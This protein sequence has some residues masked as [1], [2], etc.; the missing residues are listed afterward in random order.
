MVGVE[1]GECCWRE[2]VLNWYNMESAWMCIC[3]IVWYVWHATYATNQLWIW[4]R[5]RA[6][7]A[8]VLYDSTRG[9]SRTI[10]FTISCARCKC[11]NTHTH[12]PC[13]SLSLFHVRI[14]E[15]QSCTTRRFIS[16][17]IIYWIMQCNVLVPLSTNS[18]HSIVHAHITGAR[19]RVYLNIIY[20]CGRFICNFVPFVLLS[21]YYVFL[22]GYILY[23]SSSL[24]CRFR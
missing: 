15:P 1:K 19:G 24:L 14:Y 13:L 6:S 3:V 16:M 11:N 9:Q 5:A 20:L 10:S 17:I 18:L 12:T 21:F 4:A 7:F 23:L 8:F 2:N 22:R